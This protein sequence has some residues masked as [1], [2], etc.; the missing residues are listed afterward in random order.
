LDAKELS[1]Y[2]QHGGASQHPNSQLYILFTASDQLV[3][4]DFI[5]RFVL[6]AR[7]R[8]LQRMMQNPYAYTGT[9]VGKASSS[10]R[11]PHI[12]ANLFA[13]YE[14]RH[15]QPARQAALSSVV[16]AD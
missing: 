13:L 9:I 6:L 5:C 14:L 4:A 3:L 7:A 11:T 12:S 10:G 8:H 15:K 16:A 2:Q 1:K